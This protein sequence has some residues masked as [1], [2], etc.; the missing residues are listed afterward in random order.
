[1]EEFRKIEGYD[2]Y[3]VSNLGN[4]K[5]IK[6]QTL[7]TQSLDKDGYR[8]LA[9]FQ[10]KKYTHFRVHRLVALMWLPNPLNKP[11]IDHIDG[12]KQNN[13]VNNL[14]WATF[15]ENQFNKNLN[16]NSTSGVK[17]I[18]FRKS[19]NKWEA[20]IMLNGKNIYIGKYTNLEEAKQA[21]KTKAIE[22]FGEFINQC[23][24]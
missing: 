3:E 1:M 16:S 17:G 23:E 4:V 14:R 24:C 13:N 9:L 20:S 7:L 18:T 21:R 5:N 8:K 22:L 11:V 2:N 6:R 19:S 10:N 15:Q 12:N